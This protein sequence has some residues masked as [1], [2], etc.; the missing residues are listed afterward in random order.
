VLAALEKD[1]GKFSKEDSTR[2]SQSLG[3][4]YARTGNLKE[5]KRDWLDLAEKQP[6]NLQVR[7]L[8]FDVALQETDDTTL[9]KLTAEIKALEGEEGTLWKYGQACRILTQAKKGNKERLDEARRLLAEVASRR[10]AWAQV[11][12]RLGDLEELEGHAQEATLRYEEAVSMGDRSE[13]T[14]RKLVVLLNQRGAFREAERI[15]N[16]FTKDGSQI[17]SDMR[18]TRDRLA[19]DRGQYEEAIVS[20]RKQA[21]DS[22]EPRDH[23]WLGYVLMATKKERE[24]K[25]AEKVLSQAITM[26]GAEKLIEPW[27]YLV[28]VLGTKQKQKALEVIKTAETRLSPDIAPVALSECYEALGE[29]D[30]AQEVFA[31]ALKKDADNLFFL[32]NAASFNM[33]HGQMDQAMPYV[34]RLLKSPNPDDV[35]WARRGKAMRLAA[36]HEYAR[37]VEAEKLIK[38]NIDTGSRNME[39]YRTLAV[40]QTSRPD[41]RLEALHTLE[42]LEGQG[43]VTTAEQRLIMAQ[44][45]EGI[46]GP[47]NWNKARL[48]Y[49]KL[50]TESQDPNLVALCALRL[51]QH[52]D[53]DEAEFALKKLKALGDN[54][55]LQALE[56]QVLIYKEKKEKELAAKA[57]EGYLNTPQPKRDI[58]ASLYERIDCTAEAE[59]LYQEL[60][61]GGKLDAQLRYAGFLGRQKRLGE[62]FAIFEQLWKTPANHAAVASAM[63]QTLGPVHDPKIPQLESAKRM[64]AEAHAKEP[65]LF[66]Y[67]IFLASVLNQR[68]EY[69]DSEKLYREVL[70]LD[71]KNAVALNNLAWLL[72]VYRN[73]GQ[74]ALPL[75]DAAIN[76]VGPQA[77]LLDT[78]AVI[79]ISMG[80]TEKAIKDLTAALGDQPT[81]TM[82]FHRAQALQQKKDSENALAD[83]RM[84]RQ[85]KLTPDK[86]HPLE[87]TA[88]VDLRRQLEDL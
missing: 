48:T 71:A 60:A 15:L 80:Q 22:K 73:K 11:S 5:A 41:R 49:N 45:Y 10:P 43:G 18:R 21:K 67:T 42:E 2:L 6:A 55:T 4:L 52:G 47:Q 39:D 63:M 17:P 72:A 84:A 29:M 50:A 87:Q 77:E 78:R 79:Y 31:T 33:R 86:L 75:V 70:K 74:E 85:L 68:T 13:Y 64:L 27:V 56:V 35:Q 81:P 66:V 12:L 37:Y 9:D 7:L 20:A 76:Q 8:L 53:A 25:E 38:Q 36:Y 88:F 83:L 58:A 3:E 26:K 51:L 32:R 44:L 23:V 14:L 16:T 69:D 82:Y 1:T 40:I 46:P 61:S 62:A 54:A 34:E 59:K 65:N 57:I 19:L 28:Q 24:L 30:K